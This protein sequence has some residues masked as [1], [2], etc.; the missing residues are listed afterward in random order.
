MPIQQKLNATY[1]RPENA[2]MKWSVNN[3]GEG[4]NR[5]TSNDTQSAVQITFFT[6]I[7]DPGAKAVLT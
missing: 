4:G 1:W 6:V 7:I 2:M 5:S 3:F